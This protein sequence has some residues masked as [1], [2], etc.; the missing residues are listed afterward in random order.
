MAVKSDGKQIGIRLSGNDLAKLEE[1]IRRV[2]ER[3]NGLAK[4]DLSSIFREL[5]QLRQPHYVTEDD[6]IYIR[7]LLPFASEQKKKNRKTG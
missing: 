1:I 7:S 5:A 2:V 3:S 6:R 4:P